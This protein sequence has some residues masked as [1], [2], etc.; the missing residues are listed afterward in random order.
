L[1]G[2]GATWVIG[3]SKSLSELARHDVPHF[4]RELIRER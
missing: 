2:C 1:I 4:E 3:R